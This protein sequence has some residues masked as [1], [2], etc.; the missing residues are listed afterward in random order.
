MTF[1]RELQLNLLHC[2]K[3]QIK[4]LLNQEKFIMQLN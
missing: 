4:E 2:L 1:L 3:Y